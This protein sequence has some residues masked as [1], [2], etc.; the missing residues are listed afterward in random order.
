MFSSVFSLDQQ[1]KSRS[2]EKN[3]AD[4]EYFRH[5]WRVGFERLREVME[6]D[7]RVKNM[8]MSTYF[9]LEDASKAGKSEEGNFW[10][11]AKN[12][13]NVSAEALISKSGIGKPSTLR[14]L[15]IFIYL[16]ENTPLQIA[17]YCKVLKF[18]SYFQNNEKCLSEKLDH[19]GS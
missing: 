17:D 16:F 5:G 19:Y 9:I 18:R 8:K 15:R 6:R 3:K 1:S 4:R 14:S 11:L 12:T 13:K 2:D 7:K 10:K